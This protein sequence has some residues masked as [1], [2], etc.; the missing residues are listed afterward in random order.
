M[1]CLHVFRSSSPNRFP[2]VHGFLCGCETAAEG[3]A[4]S[5][6][7]PEEGSK[8]QEGSK[9]RTDLGVV[10]F[11]SW[12]RM[13]ALQKNQG[14]TD[15]LLGAM[16]DLLTSVAIPNQQ[17]LSEGSETDLP[18]SEEEKGPLQGHWEPEGP[19]WEQ[20]AASAT[21]AAHGPEWPEGTGKT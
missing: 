2:N 10:F 8:G 11:P 7:S 16:A 12:G 20:Q 3:A 21:S 15:Q 14:R 19:E 17:W 6:A 13:K 1:V 18:S 4:E 9:R 5:N